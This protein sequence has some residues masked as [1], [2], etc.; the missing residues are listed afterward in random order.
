M[1]KVYEALQQGRE[2]RKNLI[3]LKKMLKEE[4]ALDTYLSMTEDDELLASF[5]QDEDAKTRKNAALV[6]GLL[7][8]QESLDKLWDAYLAET[9]LFVKSAYL[10]AMQKLDCRV[11]EAQLKERYRQLSAYEPKEEEQKHIQEELKELRRLVMQFDGGISSHKF[12]GYHKP[13]DFVLTTLKNY[14]DTTSVQI[15]NGSTK[16]IPMG[17]QV[18]GGSIQEALKIRTFRELLFTLRCNKN[19]PPRPSVIASEFVK[20]DLLGLLNRM[21]EG[22]PV[23]YFRLEIKS[24]MPL[25][26]KSK[27]AKRLAAEIEQQTGRMLINAT[28]HYEVELR[29]IENRNRGFYPCMKLYTIPMKRFSYRKYTTASS[30]HPSMAALLVELAS[31]WLKEYAKVM[32]AFC[33]TGTLLIERMY[34][35]AV[36]TAYATDTF[37]DAIL[38]ARE[39]AA[40]AHMNINFIQ[41]DFMD[42]THEMLFDELW[43]DMPARS[44][45]TKEEQDSFYQAFFEKAPTLLAERGRI[46]LYSDENGLVK[47][48]LRLFQ[49]LQ[50]KQEFCIWEKDGVYFYIIEQKP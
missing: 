34:A 50:I 13:Q 49:S 37:G 42:F 48:Y 2:I 19:L 11:Y 17:V 18:N 3:E 27:F 23:F 44:K 29:L 41:R 32:D 39:N 7:L 47:K 26:K 4:G 33:G 22:E 15:E 35:L 8:S 21:H 28:D 5:L 36:R 40:I 24:A 25:E 14:Q 43:A 16:V 38:G 6:L 31:N 1:Q 30:M 45:K 10:A 9:Q 12:T 20:A 46:F